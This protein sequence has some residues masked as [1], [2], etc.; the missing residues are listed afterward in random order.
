MAENRPNKKKN[1]PRR[2]YDYSLLF[3]V[4][5][6]TVFGLVMIYSSS[7]YAAQIKYDDAA[8]FMMRQAKIALA[9]F[10]IMLIIFAILFIV[11]MF[12]QTTPTIIIVSPILLQIV[13][14]LGIHPIQFGLVMTLSLCIAFVTPPVASNLFVAQSMTGLDVGGITK[15]ALPFILVL[16]VAMAL[17]AFFPMFSMGILALFR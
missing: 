13:T 17:V 1:K 4:I 6:L 11:G 3:T 10:V 14:P 5:F 15:W 2:F 16:F 9:G 7:S 8:Y 12:V